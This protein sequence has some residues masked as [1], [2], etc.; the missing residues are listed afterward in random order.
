MD[1]MEARYHDIENVEH[2]SGDGEGQ[3]Y[4]PVEISLEDNAYLDEEDWEAIRERLQQTH[5][6]FKEKS[7]E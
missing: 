7:R 1:A 3:C 6:N 2:P 5:M 4:Q